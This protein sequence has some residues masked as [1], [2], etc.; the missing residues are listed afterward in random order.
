M[1]SQKRFYDIQKAVETKY[2]N[3]LGYL[4]I[5]EEES[6]IETMKF[7]VTPYEGFHKGTEYTIT[8]KFQTDAWPLV[9]IDSVIYDALKTNQYLNNRGKSGDH[10]GICIKNLSYAYAFTK[11]F[12]HYCDNK[13]EN[14]LY[15]IIT[16]FNN[17][18]DDFEKGNGIKSNYK[19]ILV[20]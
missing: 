7:K 13:W 9:F 11:N 3:D 1:E 19:D 5:C 6:N 4:E 17:F 20:K 8:L 10:K 14:Y 12:K 18:D 16:L 2:Y 15:Q